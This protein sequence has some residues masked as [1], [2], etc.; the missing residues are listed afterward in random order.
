MLYAHLGFGKK[1]QEAFGTAI[2]RDGLDRMVNHYQALIVD[3]IKR[4]YNNDKTELHIVYASK[5]L[6]EM[7]ALPKKVRQFA[8]ANCVQSPVDYISHF[9]NAYDTED[10]VSR[11]RGNGLADHPVID[12]VLVNATG[13]ILSV[14]PVKAVLDTY[15]A[16]G[17]DIKKLKKYAMDTDTF[18]KNHIFG[19]ENPLDMRDTET[20]E[21]MNPHQVL[22]EIKWDMV[23]MDSQPGYPAFGMYDTAVQWQKG[24]DLF[25]SKVAKSIE[26]YFKNVTK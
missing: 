22:P 17:V 14:D 7:H 12:D 25:Q 16:L 3:V 4:S 10:L 8:C 1:A 24:Y 11:L 5:S 2:N 9:K 18:I 20:F 6:M 13:E 21:L 26:Q 23:G 19:I 15:A